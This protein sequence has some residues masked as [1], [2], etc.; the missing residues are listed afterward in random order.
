MVAQLILLVATEQAQ[1]DF[2]M[3]N[4]NELLKT[5]D[6]RKIAEQILG[7]QLSPLPTPPDDISSQEEPA[8]QMMSQAE[9]EDTTD[10]SPSESP[11]E[12]STTDEQPVASTDSNEDEEKPSTDKE[13]DASADISVPQPTSASD[14]AVHP[15]LDFGNSGEYQQQKAKQLQ[16]VKNRSTMAELA[17]SLG[18]SGSIVGSAIAKAPEN[19]AAQ[20]LYADNS[21]SAQQIPIE[22]QK[23]QALKE[24][25]DPNSPTSQ[26]LRGVM[27]NLG[28]KYTGNPSSAQL[29]ASLPF[30]F[31]DVEAKQLAAAKASQAKATQESRSQDLQLK[32]KSYEQRAKE[33]NLL[34][35][36]RQDAIQA[37]K[38][39][40]NQ[41]KTEKAD[42]DRF[43]KLGKTLNESLAS[44]R[45]AFGTAGRS[46]QSIEN[47]KAVLA[48][49]VDPNQLDNRQVFE[50]TKTL[51]RVLSQ[52]NPTQFGAEHLNPDTARGRLAKI[53]EFITNERQG[54]QAGDFIK[55][56]G[57][58]LDRESDVTRHQ[59]ARTKREILSSYGDLRDKYPDKFNVMLEAHG[60]PSDIMDDKY[61]KEYNLNLV[62]NKDS[63]TTSEPQPASVTPEVQ[64]G[65]A[66]ELARRRQTKEQNQ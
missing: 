18:R 22:F 30:V 50:L 57:K 6:G 65:A 55:T 45:S 56:I 48:G 23:Q 61:S 12:E 59:M 24:E 33:A 32:L 63:A 41:Q 64:S 52:G 8:E 9:Q 31:K 60:L 49:E 39:Q 10:S 29:K 28:I 66:A 5:E 19:K 58:T 51:D 13:D 34:H 4:L 21:A 38:D 44:S 40:A 35:Q 43:D 36:D 7:K 3:A 37:Q 54:A 62:P 53:M 14:S 16:D 1:Q 47:A 46:F 26:A 11:Q 27:N 2:N 42:T 25:N 20:Q 15:M 17:G